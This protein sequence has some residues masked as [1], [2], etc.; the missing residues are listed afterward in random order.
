MGGKQRIHVGGKRSS[1]G[2]C[3]KG[4]CNSMTQLQVT[5]RRELPAD[6]RTVEA[7]TRE[8]FWNL[9]VP[10]C[11]EHWLVHIMR[12]AADFVPDLSFVAELDGRIVG[13][14]MTTR[15]R[16][17]SGDCELPTLSVGPVTVHPDFQ[18]R[19]IGRAMISKVV[20]LARERGTA[21]ILL[22]GHPHN[23]VGYGFRNGKD[24]GIAYEDGS[25]PL[26]L[27]A[28]VL[29][30]EAING[31]QWVARFSSVFELPP[32]FEEFD[33]LFPERE[34]TWRPSQEL[35]SMVLR[36]RLP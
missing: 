16:L 21:A 1:G 14:I 22:L 36:A 5:L 7:L 31:R 8:A 15:S 2:G 32:G 30:P 4:E 6:Y 12:S 24:L 23:Y 34:K 13:N 27:L 33:A 11:D 25:Y 28:M 9:Q 20:S 17:V 35:F 18:R 10:G 26:G 3:R 19:G 29:S